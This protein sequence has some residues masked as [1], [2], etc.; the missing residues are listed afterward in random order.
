MMPEAYIT[1]RRK[2]QMVREAEGRWMRE[3][4]I[5]LPSVTTQGKIVP[6]PTGK[7]KTRAALQIA[8]DLKRGELWVA[9]ATPALRRIAMQ[10]LLDHFERLLDSMSDIPRID[11]DPDSVP[12]EQAITIAKEI[13]HLFYKIYKRLPDK[14]GAFVDG[15]IG[16]Q[17]GN[18]RKFNRFEVYN[19]GEIVLLT[20]IDEK[21][22][23][24]DVSRNKLPTLNPLSLNYHG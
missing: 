2:F 9:P 16:I 15:L 5:S 14:I 3:M 18:D 7:G 10:K 4:Y 24:R 6:A 12:T 13:L 22:K 19:D 8:S 17:Y 20:R 11:D 23:A 21:L 1:S